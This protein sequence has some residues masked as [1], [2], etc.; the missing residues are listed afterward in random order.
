[1]KTILKLTI[2][3]MIVLPTVCE[4]SSIFPGF[5]LLYENIEKYYPETD[6]LKRKETRVY[7]NYRL[8]RVSGDYY[9][10]NDNPTSFPYLYYLDNILSDRYLRNCSDGCSSTFLIRNDMHGRYV[11]IRDFNRYNLKIDSIRFYDNGNL[12]NHTLF[13][14]NYS[15]GNDL[16]PSTL[17]V[18]DLRAQ[19]YLRDLQVEVNFTSADAQEISFDLYFYEHFIMGDP[20]YPEMYYQFSLNPAREKEQALINFASES[21]FYEIGRAL[22]YHDD[23]IKEMKSLRYTV[24]KELMFRYYAL[25]RV[26]TGI[27]T[28][29][30]LDDHEHDLNDMKIFFSYYAHILV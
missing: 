19:Y 18:F 8:R 22:R 11:S 16:T 30:P 5:S 9:F 7:N 3:F 4:A 29:I 21:R 13:S 17:I 14:S 2:L 27:Y 20:W 6:N 24:S 25:E 26:N 23:Q 12:I 28:E 10:L 15:Y 1:M